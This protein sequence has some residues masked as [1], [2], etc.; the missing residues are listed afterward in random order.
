VSARLS[1]STL[2]TPERGGDAGLMMNVPTRPRRL[3]LLRRALLAF[4]VL[5]SAAAAV[6]VG[7][8][9]Y[10]FTEGYSGGGNPQSVAPLAF[11]LAFLILVVAGLPAA[12][13]CAAS[14]T[15]Y[16]AASRKSRQ[17]CP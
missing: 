15:S 4:A 9:A 2:S 1:T 7:F 17:P 12:V 8:A 5:A 13:I 11:P 3:V 10:L 14:W 16:L 6:V